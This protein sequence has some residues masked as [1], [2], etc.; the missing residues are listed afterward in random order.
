MFWLGLI[1]SLCY[2]PGWTGASVPTQWAVLSIILPW[3]LFL[4]GPTAP[5]HRWWLVFLGYALF[6]TLVAAN[7]FNAVFALWGLCLMGLCLWLGTVITSTYLVWAGLAV[8]GAVSSALCVVQWF[9]I[10]VLPT[11]GTF[12]AG[13]YFNSVANGAILA[14]IAIALLT[15]GEILS[16]LCLM[17]GLIISQSRG[18]WLAFLI[19]LLGL[20]FRSAKVLLILPAFGLLFFLVP[21]SPSDEQRLYIWSIA[22]NNLQFFGWGP[23]AFTTIYSVWHDQPL[24]PEHVHNDILELIFDYGILATIPIGLFAWALTRTQ[25]AEWPIILTF[26]VMGFYSFPFWMPITS[27][28]AFVAAGHMLRDWALDGS[29]RNGGRFDLLLWLA[30][31]Q[32][33][34]GSNGSQAIPLV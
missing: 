23:G 17:P 12:P 18:A 14:L 9:G 10:N 24:F 11:F 6:A 15:R 8:G 3:T 5:F 4:P 21:L 27:F 33:A 26:V 31:K 7:T 34:N 32:P 19:G 30:G 13:L 22:Y 2:I 25:S 1:V 20:R 16:A 29:I 28:I